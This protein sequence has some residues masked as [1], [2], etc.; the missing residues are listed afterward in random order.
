MNYNI[1][2]Q[3][4]R[5][6][7][8]VSLDGELHVAT[9]Q[10]PNYAA[11]KAQAEA[12]DPDGLLDLFDPSVSIGKEF[13]RLSE[14]VTAANGRLFFDG[15]EVDNSLTRTVLRFRDEDLDY[16]PLVN[17]FEKVM[18]NTDQHT[19]DNLFRWLD[20]S[21]DGLAI[22]DDGDIVGYKG[23]NRSGD[24]DEATY[25]SCSAGRAI[26]DG[27]VHTGYI[28]N[29]VGAVVEMP[30][31]EVTWDP[32]VAC[33]VGLHVGT[34]DY[35]HN[36]GNGATMLVRVNPR[37][38]VSVPT[39][40]NGQKLRTCRYEVLDITDQPMKSALWAVEDDDVSDDEDVYC[41]TCGEHAEDCVA[42]DPD[43]A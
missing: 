6:V 34:W 40:C 25:Q 36:F 19:R 18:T 24:G 17:F 15:D 14:R 8:V 31:S 2:R 41:D 9:D 7:I 20:A 22:T 10:H 38:V 33:S 42:L 16:M 28:P 3:E 35:A 1:V 12:E 39:D 23:V 21:G 26:V 13:Q 11:I 27:T 37:D 30:R 43:C 29:Y 4:G 5:E 32:Q